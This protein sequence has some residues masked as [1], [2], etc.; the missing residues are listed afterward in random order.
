MDDPL[1]MYLSD[2]FTTPASLVG[3][4]AV[5]I[6]SGF[7]EQG[8]PLSLQVMGKPFGE[9]TVFRACRAFERELGWVVAPSF[10]GAAAG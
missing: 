10:K 3:L 8:L 4:P 5:A 1:A 2:I 9:A 7:D 6:P